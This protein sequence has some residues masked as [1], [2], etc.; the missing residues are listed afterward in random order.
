MSG[1]HLLTAA[2]TAVDPILAALAADPARAT[3]LGLGGRH[4]VETEHDLGA[5]AV[6]LLERLGIGPAA[7]PDA[8]LAGLDAELAALGTPDASPVAIRA[9]RRA[10]GIAGP[11]DWADLTGRRR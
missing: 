7:F 8:P 10:S 11:A 3:A 4:L 5:V 2:P 6:T 9:L 1:I